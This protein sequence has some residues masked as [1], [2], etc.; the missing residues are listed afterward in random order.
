MVDPAY[1][2]VWSSPVKP[3]AALPTLLVLPLPSIM[4]GVGLPGAVGSKVTSL[5]SLATAVHCVADGQL[6]DCNRAPGSMLTGVG[7]SQ[8]MYMA[9]NNALIQE[10][11][12]PE[13]RGRVVSTLFLNRGMVP[14]GTMMAGF[15]TDIFGPRVTVAA[16][17]A[18]LVVLAFAA[19]IGASTK[20][21]Q[22]NEA[23]VRA[24]R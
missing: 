7:F 21:R 1:Q 3:L 17:A 10:E 14:L 2:L 9:L 16:M 19:G 5:P 24:S 8:Q 6:T 12:D 18:V 13:F 4:N 20:A 11:V 22:H 23:T 15:G